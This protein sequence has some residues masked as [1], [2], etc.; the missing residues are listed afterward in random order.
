MA[1]TT[2]FQLEITIESILMWQ[3]DTCV[4][5]T[6]DSYV[7]ILMDV[8]IE[9]ILIWQ[10]GTCGSFTAGRFIWW[11][12][13]WSCTEHIPEDYLSKKA[14]YRFIGASRL[15]RNLPETIDWRRRLIPAA[16][17]T[18]KTDDDAHVPLGPIASKLERNLPRTIGWRRNEE[19][20]EC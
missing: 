16:S 17:E 19:S 7:I 6:A 12:R 20:E 11:T 3:D 4:P 2:Y 5:A 10:G 13:T 8:T 14:R 9:S 15:E 1:F 18:S